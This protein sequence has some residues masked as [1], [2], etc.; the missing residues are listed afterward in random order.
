MLQSR[1]IPQKY[2]CT[3]ANKQS[4]KQKHGA[5]NANHE[6]WLGVCGQGVGG[7]GCVCMCV[8]VTVTTITDPSGPQDLSTAGQKPTCVFV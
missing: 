6:A 3:V 7:G 4:E 5:G 1:Q 2:F 8:F